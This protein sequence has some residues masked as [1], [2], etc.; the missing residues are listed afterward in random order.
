MSRSVELLKKRYFL[1]NIKENL[2]LF[3]GIELEYPIVNLEGKAKKVKLLRISFWYLTH[4]YWALPK[5]WMILGIQF[6]C[7]IQSQDTIL[8]EVAYTT[9][10][11][12]FES[13]ESIQ[14][15]EELLLISYGYDSE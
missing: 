5:K 15:V 12:A 9:I 14:E 2:D 8:F 4:Q 11:F 7:L 3:I 6:S 10:E 13:P 1:K